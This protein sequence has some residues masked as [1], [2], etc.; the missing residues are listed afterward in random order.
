MA[1]VYDVVTKQQA[2][3]DQFSLLTP[4]EY[5]AVVITST[6]K[7]SS[8]GNAMMDVTLSVY[9]KDGFTHSVRDFLVFIKPMMWKIIHFAESA[10]VYD[11]YEQGKLCSD[12]IIN[13]RVWVKIDIEEGREIPEDRLQGKPQGSKYPAKNKVANYVVKSVNK[14]SAKA[15]AFTDDDLP[16]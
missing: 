3:S 14:E 1:L 5:E 6:D 11:I 4:G 2:L 8:S 16:F 9:D 7:L 13:K 15:Q 12:A 10:G